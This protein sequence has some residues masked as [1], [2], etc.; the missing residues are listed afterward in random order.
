M[1]EM[2]CCIA[3]YHHCR[4]IAGIIPIDSQVVLHKNDGHQLSVATGNFGLV[5][6][7]V[8]TVLCHPQFFC[9]Y[10]PVPT[11]SEEFQVYRLHNQMRIP[12]MLRPSV[13]LEH[14]MHVSKSNKDQDVA[15]LIPALNKFFPSGTEHQAKT[16]AM[17]YSWCSMTMN[18]Q[19]GPLRAPPLTR[20]QCVSF[21]SKAM[22]ERFVPLMCFPFVD[23]ESSLFLRRPALMYIWFYIPSFAWIGKREIETTFSF[24]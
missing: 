8:A 16:F 21:P 13:R 1:S 12:F 3:S 10:L 11:Q 7:H 5:L 23:V 18:H 4:H 6:L 14:G 20:E 22:R 2:K 24:F 15:N 17:C 19:P 9:L